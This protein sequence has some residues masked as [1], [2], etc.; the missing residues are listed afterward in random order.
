M[1][2]AQERAIKFDFEFKEKIAGKFERTF[3][4]PRPT[5]KLICDMQS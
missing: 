4:N 3:H 5:D 1:M 2:M